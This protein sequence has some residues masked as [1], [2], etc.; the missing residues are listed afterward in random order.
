MVDDEL[1]RAFSSLKSKKSPGYDDISS[2]FIEKA[3]GYFQL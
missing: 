2:N 1:H 3:K